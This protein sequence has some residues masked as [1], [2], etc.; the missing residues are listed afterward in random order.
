L[1]RAAL[2]GVLIGCSGVAAG[3]LIVAESQQVS[4][5]Y[6]VAPIDTTEAFPLGVDPRNAT[7]NEQIIVDEFYD[8]F[9]AVHDFQSNSRWSRVT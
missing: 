8:E 3:M 9:L 7:I 1:R 2:L 6:A 5:S 4:Y